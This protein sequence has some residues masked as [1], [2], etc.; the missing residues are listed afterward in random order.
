MSKHPQPNQWNSI[1]Y[2]AYKPLCAQTKVR[3]FPNQAGAARPHAIWKY[4]RMLR[5][6][7]LP[8]ERIAEE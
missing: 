5:K 2:Q 4:K 7:V 3:S 6:M 1:D 8:G